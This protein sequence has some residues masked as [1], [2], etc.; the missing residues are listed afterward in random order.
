[1]SDVR[2]RVYLPTAQARVLRALRAGCEAPPEVA[3]ELGLRLGEAAKLLDR[4]V[5]T[6]LAVREAAPTFQSHYRGA[7]PHFRYSPRKAP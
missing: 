7:K 1:M 3:E 2:A 5:E 6:G 4:L